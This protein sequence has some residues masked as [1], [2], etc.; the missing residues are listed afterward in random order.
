MSPK[1]E[2]DTII[3]HILADEADTELA[4]KIGTA[5]SDLRGR[6]ITNFMACVAEIL[7]VKLASQWHC[8]SQNASS[9][10]EADT[11]FEVK[12]SSHPSGI[13]VVIAQDQVGF[14]KIPYFAVRPEVELFK[15][16]A[17]TAAIST[18]FAP[19][20]DYKMG[21]LERLVPVPLQ[22]VGQKAQSV[23]I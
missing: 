3:E 4:L 10:K 9:F 21:I 13:R 16:P 14:P 22:A 7:R 6:I 17:L 8:A 11:L 1:S 2:L 20:P 23:G 5:D 12:M 19:K 15:T 18:R